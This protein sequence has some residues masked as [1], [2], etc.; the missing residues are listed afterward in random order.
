[1]EG[2]N[3]QRAGFLRQRKARVYVLGINRERAGFLPHRKA[4]VDIIIIKVQRTSKDTGKL[5]IY[6]ISSYLIF[7]IAI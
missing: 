5:R 2:I 7:P 1:M 6:F 4:R 3:K